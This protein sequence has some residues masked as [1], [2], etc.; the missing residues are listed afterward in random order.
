VTETQLLAIPEFKSLPI[1]D[2]SDE[3]SAAITSASTDGIYHGVRECWTLHE[4]QDALKDPRL[5]PLG[6]LRAGGS[7]QIVVA[8]FGVRS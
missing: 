3:R 1:F 7:R 4:V 6:A 5:A 8:Y 2:E